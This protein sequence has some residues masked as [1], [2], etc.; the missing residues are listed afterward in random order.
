[1]V[2]GSASLPDK[3]MNQ[4]KDISGHDLLERFGMTEIGMG[5]G[6]PYRG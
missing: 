1:M 5:L 2:S 6:N 4:W 3:I